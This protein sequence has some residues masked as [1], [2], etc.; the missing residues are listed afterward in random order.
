MKQN[1]LNFTLDELT[2]LLVANNFKK[3]NAIQIFQ[4]IYK[5]RVNSFNEMT[6]LSKQLILFLNE[7]F[8][9]HTLNV[10]KF[11]LDPID[12]TT[13]FLFELSDGNLIETVLM[14]FNYGL[15]VCVTTQVGC[16]MGCKFCASGLLK[17][18]RNL[19][20]YEIVS[21]IY[22]VQKYLDTKNKNERI[23]NIVVMGIGEPFD[24]LVEVI[25]FIRIINNDNGLQI[26]WRKITVS[27]CGLVNKFEEWQTQMPQV[28]L[29][30]SL[31]APNDEIRNKI[32]P[33][34]RAFNLEKLM[35]AVKKYIIAT[36]RRI[37]FEYIMLA[38]VNDSI[39]CAK[40]LVKLLDNVLCYVN[41]IPYNSVKENEFKRSEKVKE[42]ANYLTKHHIQVTIRQE[43][44]RKID[45]ACGQLRA[46][47]IEVK[48]A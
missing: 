11:Q 36:N 10:K 29:A 3:F 28:G 8:E 35:D 38:D 12:E 9:F 37:T 43:K 24:N 48:N 6:N 46:K 18:K 19:S 27:T 40:Q 20:A 16:N 34:N 5:K 39:E 23:S 26:G 17:K 42:F 44:G 22:S 41:L 4:W 45:A 32:M 1:I 2:E 47:N 14:K 13:K 15:S 7:N 31:H 30:I 21:Q 33:I 25:K